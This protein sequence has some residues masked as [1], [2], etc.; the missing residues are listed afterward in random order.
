V[1]VNSAAQPFAPDGTVADAG[2]SGR[3]AALADQVVDF[4][5]ARAM[6]VDAALAS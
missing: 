2:L 1:L 3:L 5:R 6:L 4:A